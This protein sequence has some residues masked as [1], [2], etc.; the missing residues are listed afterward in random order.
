MKKI[1]FVL[2]TFFSITDIQAQV[3]EKIEDNIMISATTG[4]E[5]IGNSAEVFTGYIDYT[6]SE[7]TSNW[8][9]L[10]TEPTGCSIYRVNKKG[11]NYI[12]IFGSISL[13]LNDCKLTQDQII[14]FCEENYEYLKGFN[15]IKKG[16][17]IFLF[18]AKSCYQVATVY[19]KEEELLIFCDNISLNLPLTGE[20]RVI[21]PK[22]Y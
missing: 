8:S 10:K 4:K 12:E 5:V 3:V 11:A 14:C 13:D 7:F 15:P 19:K 20:I 2:I 22:I 6:F 17:T 9:S 16:Y 1:L 18:E 21:V